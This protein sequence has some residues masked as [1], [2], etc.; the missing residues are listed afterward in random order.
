MCD[1][2]NNVRQANDQDINQIFT[3]L[4]TVYFQKDDLAS[5]VISAFHT[6]KQKADETPLAFVQRFAQAYTHLSSLTALED[7]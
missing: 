3:Y 7:R 1:F 6:M 4:E 2:L 5:A